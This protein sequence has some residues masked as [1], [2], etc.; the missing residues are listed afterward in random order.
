[1]RKI[2]D[3]MLLGVIAGL[4]GNVVK[5]T[6][7]TIFQKLK[8]AELGSPERAAG[9]LIPPHTLMHKKGRMV[10]Y[11]ADSV[12]SGLLG[13]ASVYAFSTFGKN[14]ATLKGALAGQASWTFLYGVLG[15]MGV[16][17]VSPVSPNT[18]LSEFVSHTAFGAT[19]A[20]IIT[21]LGDS[22][23][24]DGT[25]PISA[26]PSKVQLVNSTNNTVYEPTEQLNQRNAAK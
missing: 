9:M 16:T 5:L 13:T 26:T 21:R 2:K 22:S 4:G 20:F 25:I 1:M 10:G 18:V 24:F 15:T 17:K 19:S 8:W 14:K 6:L 11:L 23:L 3:R 12:V 7:S